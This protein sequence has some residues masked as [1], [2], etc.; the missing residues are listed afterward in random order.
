MTVTH[1]WQTGEGQE[2]R[3]VCFGLLGAHP[4]I[5]Y[6]TPR[7]VATWLVGMWACGMKSLAPPASPHS[8]NIYT[9]THCWP[10]CP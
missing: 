3:G 7:I 5:K 9:H 10:T 2:E 8:P 4:K 6:C 1:P